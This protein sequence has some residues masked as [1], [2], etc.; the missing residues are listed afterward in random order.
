MNQLSRRTF[1]GAGAAGTLFGQHALRSVRAAEP[2]GEAVH[3]LFDGLRS[4]TAE[5]SQLLARLAKDGRAGAD[6]YLEGGCVEEL[7]KQFAR[8][9]G[10]EAALFLPTGTLANHLAIRVQSGAKS[11][12]LVQAESHVYRDTLDCVQTLSHLNLVPLASGKATFPIAEVEESYKQASDKP[13]PMRVGAISIEC[14]VRRRAGEAFDFA[15]MKRIAAFARKHEIKMHLDGAR[16]FIASAYTNVTPAEYAALFDTVYISLYKYFNA[17]SGAILAGP[18]AV[19]EEVAHYRKVFGGGMCMGWPY[20]AVALHYFNGFSERFQKAVATSKA[21]F[22]QLEKHPRFKV[23][24]IANGTNIT[25]LQVKDVD[26]AKYH[27]ALER[28]GISVRAPR[29]E[30]TEFSLTTNESLSRRSADD[31]AKAFIAA[32]GG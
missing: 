17:G 1:I 28:Q 20:A 23:E 3:F 13:Y 9:L 27:A 22:A 19:I 6:I 5:H 26:G 8:L 14:P 30:T 24:R 16:L 25:R 7:E 32:L 2:A 12:V 31:L 29:G 21:L 11:R 10:K 18:G 15:E 4:S